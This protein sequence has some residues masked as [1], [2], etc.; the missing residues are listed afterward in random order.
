MAYND[1]TN[2]QSTLP[3]VFAAANKVAAEQTSDETDFKLFFSF[4]Y[5]GGG[6][7]PQ[8][9][10]TTLIEE[11]KTNEAYFMHNGQPLVS[12][13][14]G[15][16][17]AD[18]WD[19]IKNATGCFFIPSWSSLGAKVAMQTKVVD[20]LFNW[21]AW[22]SGPIDMTT[23]V[24]D[25]Y[26]YYLNGSAYMMPVS[27]WFYTNLPGYD[28]N[29]LW[30]GDS[31]WY[32]RWNQVFDLQPE[33]V[34]IISWNDFGESHYIGPLDDKAY[35]AFSVGDALY[36]FAEG[37][38]HDAFRH[39]LPYLIETYKNG[40]GTAQITEE[41]LQAWYRLTPGA[42]CA[43][44]N[45]TGNTASQG[46]LEYD[47]LKLDQDMVFFSALLNA[48]AT[49][50]VTIGG[51]TSDV[52]WL[53]TPSDGDAGVYHAR[54]P[55]GSDPEGKVKISISRGGAEILTMTGNGISNK[56]Q[57]DVTNWNAWSGTEKT[58]SSAST[59]TSGAVLA[60]TGTVG[61]AG[62]TSAPAWMLA[63][64]AMVMYALS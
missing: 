50:S 12:T 25:S 58:S 18:Q 36:N 9:N 46:E 8:K 45:T 14:E 59:T 49:A 43:S 24:D 6:L 4:D 26:V 5:A 55:F 40:N 10:V 56:C 3:I 20:G 1:P 57:D 31:L 38:P 37:M 44:G 21:D 60:P 11:Y 15:T 17:S 42:A 41:G 30:R 62:H 2:P 16:E 29:W 64:I 52:A 7:W 33:F 48:S 51:K 28:K 53:H 22:P 23:E 39:F 47:P 32:D 61:A 19:E 34:E 35:R 27:P 13:F 63:I 54:V